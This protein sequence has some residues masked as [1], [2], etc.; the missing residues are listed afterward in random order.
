MI[1]DMGI[2][3]EIMGWTRHPHECG[4]VWLS[5]SVDVKLCVTGERWSATGEQWILQR[6]LDSA[7]TWETIKHGR[8]EDSLRSALKALEARPVR[9]RGGPPTLVLACVVYGLVV[10]VVAAIGRMVT[11]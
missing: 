3:L 10:A 6:W 8:G 1:V 5:P 4:E 11:R 7:A 9:S 2:E